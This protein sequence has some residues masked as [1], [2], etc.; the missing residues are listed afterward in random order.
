M[1]WK[2]LHFSS[3]PQPLDRPATP[4]A[5]DFGAPL[6]ISKPVHVMDILLVK[7]RRSSRR[8]SPR[9]ELLTSNPS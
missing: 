9:T 7:T 3:C 6:S 1:R 8:P 4:L 5:I 2:G